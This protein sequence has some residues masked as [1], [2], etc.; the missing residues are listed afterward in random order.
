MDISSMP[1]RESI[2]QIDT[3]NVNERNARSRRERCFA[4][5]GKNSLQ[6]NPRQLIDRKSVTFYKVFGNEN[7]KNSN[8]QNSV[9]YL[10]QILPPLITYV[11]PIR[12]P[13]PIQ[14]TEE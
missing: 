13:T 5:I 9:R 1:K 7:E 3:R 4:Y 2:L 10:K 12:E 6:T 14:E 8:G 11:E